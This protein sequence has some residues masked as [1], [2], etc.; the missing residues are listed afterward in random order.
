MCKC[1][2]VY[3]YIYMYMYVY[4]FRRD[5]SLVPHDASVKSS[6]QA[7]RPANSEVENHSYQIAFENLVYDMWCPR[8]L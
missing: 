7:G 5:L 3:M 4:T 6:L 2:H 8:W 1:V